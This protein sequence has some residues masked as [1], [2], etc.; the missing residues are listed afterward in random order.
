MTI[1]PAFSLEWTIVGFIFAVVICIVFGLYPARK[2]A[3]LELVEAL[4]YE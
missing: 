2:A 3:K 1:N 4:R